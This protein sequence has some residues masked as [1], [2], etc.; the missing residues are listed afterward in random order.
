MDISSD[1][2]KWK[3]VQ[4]TQTEIDLELIS[5][6]KRTVDNYEKIEDHWRKRTPIFRWLDPFFS[7]HLRQKPRPF[8]NHLRAP[9]EEHWT[10]DRQ[11]IGSFFSSEP[12]P[13]P[14]S[15]PDVTAEMALVLPLPQI[16]TFYV[17]PPETCDIAPKT[18][19]TPDQSACNVDR[20]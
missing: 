3:R 17:A 2:I 7:G 13:P 16:S 10:A 6:A 18:F 12:P 5:K 20:A 1:K 14:S 19:E 8:S 9:E 4:C 11:D 15:P